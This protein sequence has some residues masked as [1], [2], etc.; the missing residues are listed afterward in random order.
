[1][2]LLPRLAPLLMGLALTACASIDVS[3]NYDPGAVQ[4]LDAYKTYAW[5]PQP[6]GSDK[7]VYNPI[8]GGEVQRA[9]DDYLQSHGYQKVGM[10][11][12]PDFLIGWHGAIDN[13]IEADTVNSYYGY[14]YDPMWDPFY[15]GG[16]VVMAAPET[17]V[18]EYEQGTLLLDIVDARSKKLVWRGQAQ[19]EIDDSAKAEK[20]QSK[21]TK[22][23][24]KMLERFPP[25]PGKK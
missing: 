23:V 7:R 11:D 5:L 4:Q 16:P 2:R 12:N 8:V 14:P 22:A 13:K 3:S 25:K 18:R 17:Y 10:G 20:Q 9:A 19:S 21:I 1:M 6:E 24:T 15:G